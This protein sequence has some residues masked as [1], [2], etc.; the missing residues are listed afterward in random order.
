MLSDIFSLV[1]NIINCFQFSPLA[2]LKRLVILEIKVSQNKNKK[3]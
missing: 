1:L 2:E 3:I